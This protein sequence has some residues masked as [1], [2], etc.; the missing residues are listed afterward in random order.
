MVAPPF[1]VGAQAIAVAVEEQAPSDPADL[2]GSIADTAAKF[3]LRDKPAGVGCR[4]AGELRRGLDRH[5]FAPVEWRQ[6]AAGRLGEKAEI[7]GHRARTSAGA[8]NAERANS[9][10]SGFSAPRAAMAPSFVALSG[11]TKRSPNRVEGEG[12]EAR[13]PIFPNLL[14]LLPDAGPLEGIH[15]ARAAGVAGPLAGESEAA[16]LRVALREHALLGRQALVLQR[17]V[18]D[19]D[20][21]NPRRIIVDPLIHTIGM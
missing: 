19:R 9:A 1:V 11:A 13:H 17:H 18:T 20:L 14:D 7:T 21:H 2:P 5:G 6:D 4:V 3:P 10:A 8:C 15:A 16:G 12:Q